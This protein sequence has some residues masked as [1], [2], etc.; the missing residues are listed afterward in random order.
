MRPYQRSIRWARAFGQQDYYVISARQRRLWRTD[1]A[2][3]EMYG[4]INRR[5]LLMWGSRFDKR[6]LLGD[7]T[8]LQQGSPPSPPWR[9]SPGAFLLQDRANSHGT[10]KAQP[11]IHHLFAFGLGS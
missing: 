2:P 10:P 5:I 1:R 7:G 4:Q 9:L 3:S 11:V 6:V 8:F